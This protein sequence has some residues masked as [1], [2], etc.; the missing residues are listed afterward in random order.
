M[1]LLL[2]G[3]GDIRFRR[4][5]KSTYLYE[6]LHV[7]L[8]TSMCQVILIHIE[9]Y[10]MMRKHINLALDV[11]ALFGDRNPQFWVRKDHQG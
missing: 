11:S 6:S 8:S 9:L 4:F 1:L 10:G 7:L 3:L 2:D 5:A